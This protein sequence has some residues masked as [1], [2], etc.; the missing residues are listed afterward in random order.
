MVKSTFSKCWPVTYGLQAAGD[1][2]GGNLLEMEPEERARAGVFLAFQHPPG[3]SGCQQF[4]LLRVAYNSRRKQQ[5]WRIRLFDLTGTGKTG[6]CEDE[7][8]SRS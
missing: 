5:G 2:H 8:A 7:S 6:S 4:G 1:L 3:N